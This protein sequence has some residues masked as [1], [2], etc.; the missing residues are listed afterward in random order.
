MTR[1]ERFLALKNH[2]WLRKVYLRLTKIEVE[3]CVQILKRT[4]RLDKNE[5]AHLAE[6]LY[7]DMSAKPAHLNEM[8]ELLICANSAL[9]KIKEPEMSK[10]PDCKRAKCVWIPLKDPAKVSL[11]R[12]EAVETHNINYIEMIFKDHQ[13]SASAE[14]RMYAELNPYSDEIKRRKTQTKEPQ[15]DQLGTVLTAAREKS[16]LT[17]DQVAKKLKITAAYYAMIENN[18]NAHCSDKVLGK[19]IHI[20]DIKESSTGKLSELQAAHNARA[21]A[22]DK[23]YRDAAKAKKAKVAKKSKAAP[24]EQASAG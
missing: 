4:A 14:E 17:R 24:V 5:F 21:S 2:N 9:S 3:L 11:E 20:F 13:G 6:R 19:L 18:K 7:L 23:K 22:I 16:E 15:M 8:V 12:L 1:M 10:C